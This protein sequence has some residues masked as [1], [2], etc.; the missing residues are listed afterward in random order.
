MKYVTCVCG[1]IDISNVT[2]SNKMEIRRYLEE[3]Y[4]SNHLTDVFSDD[5]ITINEEWDE[6]KQN[7]KFMAAMYKIAPHIHKD[8][9]SLILCNGEREGDIWGIILK[10]NKL[11]T[12]R[13]ELKPE[14]ES[15]EY[16]KI[17]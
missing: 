10:N 9:S 1:N 7:E 5:Q 6:F 11:Y 14:G 2:K 17:K 16:E 12:Q 15:Q 4:N 8:T 13:Y 3:L